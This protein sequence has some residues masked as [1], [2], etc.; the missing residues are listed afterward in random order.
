MEYASSL[1]TSSSTNNSPPLREEGVMEMYLK[2]LKESIEMGNKIWKIQILILIFLLFSQLLWIEI[3]RHF[4]DKQDYSFNYKE[5][6]YINNLLI[7]V[8][9]RG[10]TEINQFS[11][12]ILFYFKINENFPESSPV[13]T[14]HSKV[15]FKNNIL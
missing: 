6:K 1:S 15:K 12:D 2:S 4:K 13:V 14:C 9:L 5:L 8:K 10:C 3:S 11:N 7:E